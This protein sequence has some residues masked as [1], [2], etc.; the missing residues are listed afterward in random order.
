MR[1]SR[2]E[3]GRWFGPPPPPPP[4]KSQKYRVLL[5]YWSESP[6]KSKSYHSMTDNNRPASETPFKWRF[7]KGA[8]MA[9]T[10]SGI[11]ILSLPYQLNKK[12]VKKLTKLCWNPAD[13]TFVISPCTFTYTDHA[14]RNCKVWFYFI[15]SSVIGV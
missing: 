11:W 14:D 5:Q 9:A 8:M 2:G 1:E 12:R 13:K 4:G 10:F 15:L 3:R 7:A 6:R